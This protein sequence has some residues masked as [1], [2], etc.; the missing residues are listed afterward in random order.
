MI[1]FSRRYASNTSGA[2][3]ILFGLLVPVLCLAMGGAVDYL[4][5]NHTRTITASALDSAVLAGASTL[6]RGGTNTEA[7]AAAQEH[8]NSNVVQRFDIANDTVAF[9]ITDNGT[10]VSASGNANI[11]TTFLKIAGIN[12]LPLF[13]AP[14]AA[15]PKAKVTAGGGD[16]EVALML[17]VTG[18]MCDDGVGPCTSGSKM[19]AL[20]AAAKDLVNFVVRDNQSPVTSRVALV[21][22]A[23]HIRVAPDGAG[24]AMMQTLTNMNGTWSGWREDCDDWQL[25]TT[26]SGEVGDHYECTDYDVEHVSNLQIMPCVTDRRYDATGEIGYTDDAPG[27][28]YWLNAY[29]GHR[30]PISLDSAHSPP[31]SGFGND[32]SDPM[33]ESGNYNSGGTCSASEANQVIPLSSDRL[34]LHSKI[35]GFVGEQATAGPVATAFTWYMLSPKWSNVWP[36]ESTPG[37]YSDLTTIQSNGAPKLRKVAVIMSDGVYNSYRGWNGRDQQQMSDF[38]TQLCTNMKA[39]GIE[40][41]TVGFELDSLSSN[42][43]SI[44]EATLQSCGTDVDHFYNTMD[45]GELRDAFRDIA[46]KLGSVSLVR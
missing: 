1:Y 2:T 46:A 22:F 23:H 31:S 28:G 19:D 45:P 38:A 33:E 44:A 40:I 18:S 29:R 16:I 14:E 17:D 4:R 9:A 42:E 7:L 6:W 32:A 20:K 25:V 11:A 43:R 30:K 12:E 5:L 34:F 41:Y 21:P 8:Y 26:G 10:A 3:A 39:E 36:A 37:P 35:D 27:T 24:G 15:L 13:A